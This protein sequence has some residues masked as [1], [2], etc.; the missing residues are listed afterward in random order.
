[1][2]KKD[3]IFLTRFSGKQMLSFRSLRAHEDVLLTKHYRLEAVGEK[4]RI[5]TVCTKACVLWV[6]GCMYVTSTLNN[7]GWIRIWV[8]RNVYG[9]SS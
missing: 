7:F 3:I 4:V 1:M 5:H 9:M 8:A 2:S 6:V